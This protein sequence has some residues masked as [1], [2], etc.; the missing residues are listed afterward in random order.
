MLGKVVNDGGLRLSSYNRSCPDR[1]S[2][3]PLVLRRALHER[4]REYH[5]PG[6]PSEFMA[7]RYDGVDL[8][9]VI[10]ELETYV[11]QTSPQNQSGSGPG[12]V[13]ITASN[14]PRCGRARALELTERVRPILDALYPEWSDENDTSRYFEFQA[15][16]D[17]SQKL[18]ARIKS[19]QEV[20]SMLEG[21]DAA[22]QLSASAMHELVWKA[23]SAQWSTG[24]FHEAVLAA[25]KAV[26]SILQ[27]KLGRRDL[28]DVKLVQEAFSKNDPEA[29]RPRLRFPKIKD[30][31]T[32]ESMRQGVM[33]FGA[34]CFQAI[35]NPVGHL[36]N[37]EHELSEQA[38]LERLA[39][40][41]LLARWIEDAD[42]LVED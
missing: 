38:A 41:S 29:G 19:R 26:N 32:R 14:S 33:S 35:R 2:A 9:A 22:P 27:T 39:A 13:F 31:Q 15:Q 5:R 7:T 24:H 8:N 30:E 37:E 21:L 23:A 3:L 6:L 1:R 34:G 12:G 4:R 10:S 16:R 18:L 20:A 25:S 42:L 11:A 36:P 17:A 28:S 40:F